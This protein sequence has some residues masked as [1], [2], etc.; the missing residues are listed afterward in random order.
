[1]NGWMEVRNS[2]GFETQWIDRAVMADAG[3]AGP[4]KNVSHTGAFRF[5]DANGKQLNSANRYTLS[6]DMNDLPPVSQFWSIPIYDKDGYFVNNEINRYTINSFMLEQD[7]L[8]IEDGKLIIYVQK[9]KPK[10]ANELKNWLPAP[11]GDFRFT[12]RF[13]GPSMSIING[14]YNMPQPIKI[15]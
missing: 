12:A 13:Y 10:N 3:W 6:F 2:G 5:V 7:K 4:D 9:D 15:K 11:E 14:S 8:H 1:M